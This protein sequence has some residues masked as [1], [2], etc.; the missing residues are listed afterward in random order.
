MDSYIDS[1]IKKIEN[2]NKN[3]IKNENNN[4]TI[5]NIRIYSYNSRGFDIIKQ[6]ICLDLMK[7]KDSVIPIIC[8]Q[9]NFVLKGNSHIIRK[10]LDEYHVYIKPAIKHNFDGRP[11]NGMFIGVPKNLRS[12]SKDISPSNYRIQAILLD[13]GDCNLMIINVYFPPDPKTA[14]YN[15]DSELENVLLAVENLVASH[16]CRNVVMVGDM[17]TE[18]NRKN[19]RVDR[20]EAFLLTNKLESSWKKLDVD[21]THEFEKEGITYTS[22]I[23][24]VVWNAALCKK[25]LDVGVLHLVDN[26][27]DHDPIYCDVQQT[28][29]IDNVSPPVKPRHETISTRVLEDEDWAN[30][31]QDLD[32]RLSNLNIPDCIKCRDAHCKN[33]HHIYE[34]DVYAKKILDEIDSSIKL[35]ASPKRQNIYKAKIVPGWSELVKPF[36]DDAKFWHAIWTSASRPLNTE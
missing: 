35:V 6:K 32:V 9:E 11:I 7:V 2:E 16:Q 29:K 36:G 33:M 15:L 12:K 5:R 13:T 25:V 21:Y 14:G 1:N 28:F 30:F 20:F 31:K 24:H 18:Y 17:N 10:A 26:T 19:G 8:N 3:E 22:T 27:S 4:K 23:D 34:V